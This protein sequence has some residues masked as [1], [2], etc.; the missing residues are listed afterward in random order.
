MEKY[1]NKNNP[2]GFFDS[3]I[4][5]L[6]VFSKFTSLLP[7]E[8]TLYFG[9]LKNMP[10]GNKRKEE[11]LSYARHIL[12]FFKTQNVKAVV[13]ACNTSSAM[14]YD[15]VKGEY[16]FP[17]FPIIQSSAKVISSMKIAT[18]GVFATEATIKSNAYKNEILKYN[19]N[20]NIIQ[21]A[22]PNWV[23]FIENNEINSE[24]CINDVKNKLDS[25]MEFSPDKII[26]G[27]T[28]Y[29][30]LADTMVKIL[31]QDIFIDPAEIFVRFIKSELE[32][33]NLIN[34]NTQNSKNM[35]FVSANPELFMLNAEFFYKIDN[36]PKLIEF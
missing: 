9:D 23:K 7:N 10:Y 6:S 22:C 32:K 27:C 26:L 16:S 36:L 18:L 14:I 21:I 17:I 29:P 28:H 25:M 15:I 33:L 4:G 20:I 35:F 11:L 5:G 8:N 19:K 2:I 1:S 34:D 13:I 31:N 3:G 30:Y 12:N 24:L